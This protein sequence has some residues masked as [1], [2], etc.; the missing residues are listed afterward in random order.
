MKSAA[1]GFPGLIIGGPDEAGRLQFEVPQKLLNEPG[2][3][4]GLG[5]RRP[6]VI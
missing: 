3:F 4:E 5:H 1:G 2:G 6:A